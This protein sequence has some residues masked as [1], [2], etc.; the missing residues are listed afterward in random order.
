[1]SEEIDEFKNGKCKKSF[2]YSSVVSKQKKSRK[3]GRKSK[4]DLVSNLKDLCLEL[5]NETSSMIR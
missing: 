1:M 3:L 4:K 2:K 5:E